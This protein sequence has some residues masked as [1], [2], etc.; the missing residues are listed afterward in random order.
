MSDGAPPW[1][2]TS[3][4]PV[5][6]GGPLPFPLPGET[7]G[8]LPFPLPGETG[9]PLPLPGGAPRPVDTGGPLP[10]PRPVDT[11]GPLPLRPPV[12]PVEVPG[13][14][15]DDPPGVEP[16]PCVVHADR[17]PPAVVVVRGE[18]VDRAGTQF[19]AELPGAAPLPVPPAPG[20][21]E[22]SSVVALLAPRPDAAPGTVPVGDD[23]LVPTAAVSLGTESPNRCSTQAA[24]CW[25]GPGSAPCAAA[26]PPVRKS[27]RST[28]PA[29][30]ALR[31]TG[32]VPRGGPCS[33]S[34]HGHCRRWWGS[35]HIVGPCPG[36]CTK[37]QRTGTDRPHPEPATYWRPQTDH[38]APAPHGP[39]STRPDCS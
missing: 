3:L 31:P 4:R 14:L 22:V 7:G 15:G 39:R 9:G 21:L 37:T 25:R 16:G 1:P 38:P 24:A 11:G 8:P 26:A 32:W 36:A 23:R 33:S 34:N 35:T 12:P 2:G 5:D 10:L 29:Q 20:A 19:G 17:F 6:T 28:T 27:A 13:L 30:P 18:R